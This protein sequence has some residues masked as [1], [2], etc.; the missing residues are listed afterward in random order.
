VLRS[1]GADFNLRNY[2]ETVM[3][4]RKSDHIN[5]T[6]SLYALTINT[7]VEDIQNAST[8]TFATHA[9]YTF[10]FASDEQRRAFIDAINAAKTTVFD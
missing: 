1:A 7:D 9:V 10:T 4:A 6:R 2:E 3:D 8:S 5:R